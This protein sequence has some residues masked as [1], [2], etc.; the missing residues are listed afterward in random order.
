MCLY[1]IGKHWGSFLSHCIS[2]PS[3]LSPVATF[4]T[5]G[6]TVESVEDCA[7]FW[8]LLQ[9]LGGDLGTEIVVLDVA[10]DLGGI[11]KQFNIWILV[12]GCG[13]ERR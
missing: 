1:T 12:D 3:S 7:C 10:E 4:F 5:G 2:C 9:D 11:L 6:S 8:V 13:L